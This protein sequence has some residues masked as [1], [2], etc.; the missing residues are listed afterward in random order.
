[1]RVDGLRHQG[2]PHG[3]RD[4]RQA[5]I[6]RG[7]DTFEALVAFYRDGGR[8]PGWVEVQWAKPTGAELD[9]VVEKLKALKLTVRNVPIDA[10]P[11]EGTCLFTGKPAVERVFVAKAY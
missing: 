9:A 11:A 1:M 3:Q 6:V 4:R 7:I 2:P 10:A 5:N 8:Y